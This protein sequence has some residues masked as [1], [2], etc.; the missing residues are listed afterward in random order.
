MYLIESLRTGRF[1]VTLKL[2]SRL[3]V[4]RDEAECAELVDESMGVLWF[5]FFFP[6]LHLDLRKEH[7]A[8]LRR[9]V[10]YYARSIFD[11]VFRQGDHAFG[12]PPPRT[13]DPAWSP[14]VDVEHLS[15]GA[16][17]ALRTVHRVAYEPGNESIMGHL[18][19]PLRQGLFEARVLCVDR[20]TGYRE[21][22]LVDLWMREQ[23]VRSDEG[24]EQLTATLRQA[25]FDDPR[26][27]EMFSKHSL[28]RA[29]AALHWLSVE[30]DLCVTELLSPLEDGD[31]ELPHLG[32][33]L[34]P[35][36]RFAYDGH[37][38]PRRPGSFTRV[39]FCGTDGIERLHVD[40]WDNFEQDKNLPGVASWIARNVHEESGVQDIGLTVEPL[41]PDDD[42][43]QVLAIVEGTGHTGAL[44][45]AM[46]FFHDEHQRTWSM[47]RFGTAAVPREALVAELRQTVG[48]FRLTRRPEWKKP[49]WKLW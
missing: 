43:P 42:R 19:I 46:L 36:P 22:V 31:V 6:N 18:L 30:S 5:F 29:R 8:D 28:S 24:F 13:A 21:S 37:D 7:R 23:P 41:A 25:D 11:D 20:S 40:R 1:G 17:Q 14:L 44:R 2:P 35:P 3:R 4:S 15:I 16:A 9:S 12:N 34:L 39:S 49:R 48:S 26:H 27:D 45:N 10:E 33:V 47:S 32:C 38:S